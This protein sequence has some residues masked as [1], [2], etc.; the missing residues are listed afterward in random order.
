MTAWWPR[1]SSWA[2]APA[3]GDDFHILVGVHAEAAA[4]VYGVVVEDLQG[5]E[6]LAVRVVNTA[7]VEAAVSIEPAKVG[8][9]TRGCRVKNG[10]S[11]Q[12]SWISK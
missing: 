4:P 6:R 3:R 12:E 11:H 10:G 1:E 7:R 8:M 5:P 2:S 9:D